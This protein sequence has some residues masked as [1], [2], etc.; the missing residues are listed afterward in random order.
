MENGWCSSPVYLDV[1]EYTGHYLLNFVATIM[2]RAP[3]YMIMNNMIMIK[4]CLISRYRGQTKQMSCYPVLHRLNNQILLPG[5]CFAE[6]N[7][8]AAIQS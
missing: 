1:L 3:G 2:A 8:A 4:S 5:R 6:Q 7:T